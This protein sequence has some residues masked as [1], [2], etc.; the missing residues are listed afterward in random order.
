M[1]VAIRKLYEQFSV[2]G[3]YS[4]GIKYTNP[5]AKEISQLI[6]DNHNKLHLYNVL[7]LAC[8]TGLITNTLYSLCY[9]NITGIDPFLFKEYKQNTGN[10]CLPLSFKDIVKKGLPN[11]YSCIICSFALHLCDKSMLHDLLYRLS[12]RSNSLVVIS[13]SKFPIIKKPYVESFFLT[14]KGKRIHFRKY[15]I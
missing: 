5:H 6:K 11:N 7:D 9:Y 12:E 14:D 8:G 1:S 13:P 2:N 15:D 10:V 4:S 3:F